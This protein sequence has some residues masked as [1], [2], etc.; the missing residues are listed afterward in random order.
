MASAVRKQRR[1]GWGESYGAAVTNEELH[2][3]VPLKCLD[4]L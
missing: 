2:A 1:A 4:L 3:Q